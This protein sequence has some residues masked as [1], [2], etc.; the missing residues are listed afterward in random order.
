MNSGLAVILRC[1]Q[2]FTYYFLLAAKGKLKLSKYFAPVLF[3]R[4]LLSRSR[5]ASW[6]QGLLTFVKAE[7]G[8]HFTGVKQRMD[9]ATRSG[10]DRNMLAVLARSSVLTEPRSST[11]QRA[12]LTLAP[13][14]PRGR[15]SGYQENI[16]TA[17]PREPQLRDQCAQ[18]RAQIRSIFFKVPL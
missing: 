4:R 15:R 14:S 8:R 6:E 2:R 9:L 5:F 13:L 12:A 17:R 3:L 11:C 18:P 10:I 1:V 16:L 7:A